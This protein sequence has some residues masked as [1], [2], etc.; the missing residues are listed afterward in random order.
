MVKHSCSSC[1]LYSFWLKP[2]PWRMAPELMRQKNISRHRTLRLSNETKWANDYTFTINGSEVENGRKRICPLRF[3]TMTP[4]LK[5]RSM[6]LY[7]NFNGSYYLKLFNH[8]FILS[9]EVAIYGC[10][11]GWGKLQGRF[12]AIMVVKARYRPSSAQVWLA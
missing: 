9:F 8:P 5:L 12:S 4:L 11:K 6:P 1:S 2:R 7:A 3:S 10:D